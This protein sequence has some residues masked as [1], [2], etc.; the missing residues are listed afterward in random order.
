[1]IREMNNGCC[2]K[3]QAKSKKTKK[4]KKLEGELLEV[5]LLEKKKIYS[6]NLKFL[7]LMNR[8]VF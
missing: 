7:S 3:C 1:M 6:Q 5:F 4:S 2:S 8:G